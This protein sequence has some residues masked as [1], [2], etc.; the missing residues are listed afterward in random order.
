MTSL[1][2]TQRTLG[3]L[4]LMGILLLV[5]LGIL[6][7][8]P[9]YTQGSSYSRTPSGYG[10]WVAYMTDQGHTV[11]PWLQPFAELPSDQVLTL[12]QVHSDELMLLSD[13]QLTWVRDGNTLIVLGSSDNVSN[14][15]FHSTHPT[16][17]GDIVIATRERFMAQDIAPSDR[18]I[19]DDAG[20]IAW[21]EYYGEGTVYFSTTPYLAANAYQQLSGNFAILADWATATGTSIYIDEYLHGYRDQASAAADVSGSLWNYLASTVWLPIAIQA[22]VILV[23]LIVAINQRLGPPLPAP[24]PAP[25]N[26][27]AYVEALAQVLA[28]AQSH[29]FVVALVGEAE[30]RVLQQALGLGTQLVSTPT[31]LQAWQQQTRQ[32]PQVLERI[33]SLMSVSG[34]PTRDELGFQRPIG[35][36]AFKKWLQSLKQIHKALK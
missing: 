36:R 10:A 4:A 6:G 20:L 7:Q 35:T 34:R 8:R 28:K 12:I 16:L 15:P 11:T 21:R 13:E 22:G 30:Q 31:L 1:S 3:I 14:A 2:S 17:F 18:L 33:L 32:S 27:Q 19:A 26:S 25:A 29:H 23:S 24:D 5:T 9:V